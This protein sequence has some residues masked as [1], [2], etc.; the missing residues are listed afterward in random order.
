MAAAAPRHVAAGG[1]APRALRGGAR[2]R[3]EAAALERF[4]SPGKGSGLRSRRRVRAGEL[5]YRAEPFAYVVTK[6]QLGGVCERCLRR[7][8]RAGGRH[9][10]LSRRSRPASTASSAEAGQRRGAGPGSWWG[11]GLSHGSGRFCRV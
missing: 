8:R 1:A 11:R 10:Q 9:R 4:P 2:G 6:A 7:Y 3:M 5:L